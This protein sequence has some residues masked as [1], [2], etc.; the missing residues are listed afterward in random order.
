MAEHKPSY[1]ELVEQLDHLRNS[2]REVGRIELLVRRPAPAEREPVQE[3]EI[4]TQ[5]GVVGDDWSRRPSRHTADG[6]PHPEKQVNLVNARAMQS[7]AGDRSRW[8][9]AGDQLYVDLDLSHA[10]L[11]PGTQLSVGEVVLEVTAQVHQG[12]GKFVERFGADALRFVRSAQGLSLRLRGM[13]TRV[14]R[15][16]RVRLGDS[17]RRRSVPMDA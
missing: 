14:V 17:V 15:G 3:L 6:A 10:H 4:D 7:I 8:P 13:N 11:P 5:L 2:P 1:D 12:C 9:L 16:G